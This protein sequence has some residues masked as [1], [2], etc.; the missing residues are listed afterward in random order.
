MHAHGPSLSP[1]LR[2][3]SS[4]G[5]LLFEAGSAGGPCPILYVP[6][7]GHTFICLLTKYLGISLT[8]ASRD[9]G[10]RRG[11]EWIALDLAGGGHV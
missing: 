5:A 9:N 3:G 8:G 10:H 11:K 4:P 1:A 7:L 2:G 6:D